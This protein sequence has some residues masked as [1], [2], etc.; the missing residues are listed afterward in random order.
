[1]WCAR[2]RPRQW[3]PLSK[4]HG[5]PRATR[6]AYRVE[7]RRLPGHDA[8][9]D[10]MTAREITVSGMVVPQMKPMDFALLPLGLCVLEQRQ[11]RGISIGLKLLDRDEPK[12][13]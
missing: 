4:E 9:R 11:E 10:R 2:G 1:M 13:C 7:A 5:V 8:P 12:R 6:G 3:G